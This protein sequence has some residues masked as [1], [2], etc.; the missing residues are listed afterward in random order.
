MS[1][2]GGSMQNMIVTLRNNR[3]LLKHV[4][5][6]K[7]KSRDKVRHSKHKVLSFKKFTDKEFKAFRI[8]LI[9]KRKRTK[10]INFVVLIAAVVITVLF[11]YLLINYFKNPY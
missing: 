7:N 8:K 3:N 1:G 9:E 4:T 5:A 2:G 11:F 10:I 6:F